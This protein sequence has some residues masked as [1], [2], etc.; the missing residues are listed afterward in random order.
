[1]RTPRWTEHPG[2][3]LQHL[4]TPCLVLRILLSHAPPYFSGV[5]TNTVTKKRHKEFQRSRGE[6]ALSCHKYCRPRKRIEKSV[7]PFSIY[8]SRRNYLGFLPFCSPPVSP[9]HRRS[10]TKRGGLPRTW[11]HNRNTTRKKD[12]KQGT[13]KKRDLKSTSTSHTPDKSD[14]SST[15]R[16][17]RS[18]PADVRCCARSVWYRCS[19]GNMS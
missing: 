3:P 5:P 11:Q 7:P 17:D 13:A 8:G 19:P 4:Y 10:R 12:R 14:R 9:A 16:S 2:T 15:N 1:M 18:Q 6:P